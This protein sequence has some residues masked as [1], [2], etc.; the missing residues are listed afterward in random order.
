MAS[1]ITESSK[2]FGSI[3]IAEI[4]LSET[5]PETAALEA[6]PGEF[7]LKYQVLPVR[8]EGDTL[9][10]AIGSLDKLAATDDLSVLVGRPVTPV[11][12]HPQ[13]IRDKIEERFLE[14][15]L[16]ELPAEESSLLDAEDVSDL[17]DLQKMAGEAAVVQMVNLTFAQAVRDGVSDIHIEPYER[18]VKIRF[19][20]DGIL[21]DT[22]TPPKR[23]HAALISR[24]KI[25]AEL[26]IAERRLPQDGRIKLTIAGR[27]IDVRVSIVPTVQ[28]ERAVLRIL[29]KGT[30][31]LGLEQLGM[32]S[33][34]LATFRKLIGIP[35]GMI[36]VTGPTG[37]GKSTTLYAALQEIYSPRLNILTIEDPVEYQVPGIGQIQVRANIGLT[38]ASGL[39]SI[40]RQDP[41]VIMVGEIRDHETAEIAIH[42]ALTGHLVFSTL[43]TNDASSA[44][45]RL[46]D[47]GVEPFLA[48]SSIIGV[49][50]QRLIRLNCP[51]CAQH[52]DPSPEA[53]VALGI[54]SADYDSANP[55]F[56]RG[57][58]CD[59]C[60]NTGF[61]GRRGVYELLVVDEEVRR[62]TVDRDPA[63]H[64]K[65]HAIKNQNMRTLLG[66]GR[67]AVLE[68]ITTPDEV[69]RVCQ[70]ED[71]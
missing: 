34:M 57:M 71:I 17:A 52:E 48:A 39:R 36:L 12:G 22:M 29:D 46:I 51:F 42:A 1:Q 68:G 67:L 59:K 24:L 66:D 69:L 2:E 13:L 9:V 4:D 60:G 33:D 26:N 53:L 58:G 27:Q 65:D 63:S 3:G 61:K 6:V 8:I 49:L 45:T 5:K 18:E 56:K 21:H 54:T 32:R 50:A 14:G 64:I 20:V 10:V 43:H 25:L 40:V 31:V 47:M 11:L 16:A 19:R 23:M 15:M 37:S 70:R 62:M 41:D 35:Y 44:V 30:A 55:P 28:G 38:F 7:A